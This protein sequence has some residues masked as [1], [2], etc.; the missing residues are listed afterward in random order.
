MREGL[1]VGKWPLLAR[2]EVR[3]TR[4][5]RCGERCMHE[6]ERNSGH[7]WRGRGVTRLLP[8]ALQ[9]ALAWLRSCLKGK[10]QTTLETTP[11]AVSQLCAVAA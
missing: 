1:L 10:S 3:H 6:E 2:R 7:R 8:L 9:F 5:R 4:L 11:G